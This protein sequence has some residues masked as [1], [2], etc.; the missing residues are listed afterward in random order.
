VTSRLSPDGAVERNRT[1]DLLITNQLLYQLSYNSFNSTTRNYSV[2][3][4]AS[5]ASNLDK[6]VSMTR[7][8]ALKIVSKYTKLHA[9]D[10]VPLRFY[11]PVPVFIPLVQECWRCPEP[12]I[13]S[14]YPMRG[15]VESMNSPKS[16]MNKLRGF[17]LIELM[18]VVAI[19][20][21]I[22]AV[23]VPNYIDYVRRGHV[24]DMTS[25][26]SDAKLR[27]EQRYADS[28]TYNNALCSAGGVTIQDTENYT[29]TCVSAD[30]TNQ[31]YTITGTGKGS[32]DGFVYT[33]SETGTKSSTLGDPWGGAVAAGRWVMK[34][35]G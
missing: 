6:S 27:V 22:A 3:V 8:G 34:K 19:V 13:L 20:G 1:S 14:I 30:A 7:C 25:A 26:L 24:T 31:T 5:Q 23:A 4:T 29:I 16:Q 9:H 2:A 17:T 28:R 15:K 12:T 18:I 33:V 10:A 35:G 11:P 21:I 32:I